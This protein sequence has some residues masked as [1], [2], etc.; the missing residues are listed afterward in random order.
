MNDSKRAFGGLIAAGLLLVALS[1]SAYQAP[2]AAKQVPADAAWVLLLDRPGDAATR[3][4]A[5][6]AKFKDL[7][8]D[9]DP[10]KWSAKIKA[11]LGVDLLTPEGMRAMGFDPEGTITIWSSDFEA[12]PYLAIPLSDADLFIQKM[13]EIYQRKSGKPA[14][15]PTV[16]AGVKTLELGPDRFAIKG[17]WALLLEPRQPGSK[18]G[19]P[20]KAFFGRGRKL[21]AQNAFRA[22]CKQLPE[23]L[24][25][26]AYLSMPAVQRSWSKAISRDLADHEKRLKGIT[27]AS[28]KKW[29]QG[30]V[31]GIRKVKKRFSAWLGQFV[32]VALG[33]AV[34]DGAVEWTTVASTSG[35]GKRVLAGV[36][37]AGATAPAFH[38]GLLQ[39]SLMGGWAS[40]RVSAFLD[41]IGDVPEAPWL[42]VGDGLAEADKGFREEFG[43]GLMA[44][45]LGNLREPLSL[46]LLTPDLGGLKPD[47]PM[48]AQIMQLIRFLSVARVAD[49]AK[50]EQFLNKLNEK[51]KAEG[52]PLEQ[53]QV[54]GAQVTVFKPEPGVELSWGLK[55]DV[56]LF[57]V[58]HDAVTPAARLVD[59]G[60]FR[61]A[62]ASTDRGLGQLDFA[63][64]GETMSSAVAKGI[65]GQQGTRFRMTWPIVQQ[66][67]ARFDKLTITSDLSATGLRLQAVLGVR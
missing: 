39:A 20:V 46:Y 22:A 61:L 42:L 12:D 26:M 29:M 57:G 50:A 37:P 48:D 19:D 18:H 56:F 23:Q 24:H 38:A 52:R 32:A 60:S 17:K 67:L 30:Q 21:A 31:D 58:G 35:K 44:D 14:K 27:S 6:A 59:A 63:A 16:K 4:T 15:A 40:L 45:V 62:R 1:A 28:S 10:A 53:K 34:K 64:V 33:V 5:L 65:G 11:E 25:A 3:G 55:G 49:R 54:H 66:V 13:G 36:L 9:L 51:A 2:P 47:D 41:W 43:M 7:H 8:P